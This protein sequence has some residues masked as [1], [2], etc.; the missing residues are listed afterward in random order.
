MLINSVSANN[1]YSTD[2]QHAT[3][4]ITKTDLPHISTRKHLVNLVSFEFYSIQKYI[5]INHMNKDEQWGDWAKPKVNWY[6]P[7]VLGDNELLDGNNRAKFI[8]E[9]KEDEK[10]RVIYPSYYY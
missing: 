6:D 4:T 5:F 9:N 8:E 3:N 2:I 1:S 10:K 7:T